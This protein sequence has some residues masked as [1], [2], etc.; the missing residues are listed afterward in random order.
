MFSKN[1]GTPIGKNCS[2]GANHTKGAHCFTNF[3]TVIGLKDLLLPLIR[4]S[5]KHL[6]FIPKVE[7][8]RNSRVLFEESQ[9]FLI[10]NSQVNSTLKVFRNSLSTLNIQ[11][12]IPPNVSIYD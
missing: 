12:D 9:Q 4:S 10:I 5:Q 2:P 7:K 1:S 11:R 3:F 6:T 8:L